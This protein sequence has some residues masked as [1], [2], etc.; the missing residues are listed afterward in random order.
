MARS[1]V[2]FVIIG[3]LAVLAVQNT[4]PPIALVVLGSRTAALPLSVWLLGAIAAGVITTLLLYGFAN[5]ATPA[6]RTYQPIG[7]RIRPS[8]SDSSRTSSQRTNS[9]HTGSQHPSQGN[10][11]GADPPPPPPSTIGRKNAYDTD[12]E[13]FKA[14]ERWDNWGEKPDPRRIAE[15]KAE[16]ARQPPKRGFGFKR[17]PAYSA[18][19]SINELESGW[20]DYEP[21][22]QTGG[23]PV[24]D[25]LDDIS[26]GWDMSPDQSRP[27]DSRPQDY[28]RPATRVYDSGS[29]Y[30]APG[31]EADEVISEDIFDDSEDIF[32]EATDDLEPAQVG[33]DGVYEADYRVIIPPY[34]PLDE[35][36]E[37]DA[38]RA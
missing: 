8:E 29:L 19:A 1:I 16:Q 23:S 37:D 34:K 35:E 30:D 4:T 15:T 14:P 25:S 11:L 18:D 32:G 3:L 9:Q 38:S 28:D 27:Q 6:R 13:S 12:W 5:L 10:R 17:K 26:A 7:Q 21:P 36:E 22:P 31:R 33:P 2:L 20:D 24:N